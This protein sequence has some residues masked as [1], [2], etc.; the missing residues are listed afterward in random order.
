MKVLVTGANGQLGYDIIVAL[1]ER[2][3]ANQGV[4]RVDFDLTDKN[5]TIDFVKTSHPDVI[6]HCAAYT[7][8]DRAEDEPDTCYRINVEGSRH[9]AVA[10]E[11]IGAKMLYISTDYVFSGKGVLPYEVN[12]EKEPLSVYGVTKHLGEEAAKMLVSKLFIVRTS[13][14]FGGNGQNFVKTMLRIGRQRSEISVVNDQIGSPTY[15]VDLA[16]CICKLILTNHYGT[17]HIT[18]EGDCSWFD[19]ANEIFRL[20]CMAVKVLPIASSEYPQKAKRPQNSR[21]SKRSLDN[22]CFERLP[23]WQDALTRFLREM[24]ID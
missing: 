9:I 18:N 2:G 12:S 17:Y 13:W 16:N 10:A 1:T 7:A 14:V 6:V 11:L 5:A 20:G 4:D 8:V 21:L 22:I 15:T 24:N 3:I 23:S 19:F